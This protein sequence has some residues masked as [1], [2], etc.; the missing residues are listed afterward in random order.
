M[1]KSAK[2][3]QT[4]LFTCWKATNLALYTLVC[5]Y[6]N[7]VDVSVGGED[8]RYSGERSYPPYHRIWFV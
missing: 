4:R 7:K 5:G 1:I 8:C 2:V 6:S 3:L